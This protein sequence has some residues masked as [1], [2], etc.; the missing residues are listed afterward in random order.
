MITNLIGGIGLFLLGMLLMT[1]GLRS[2]AGDALRRILSRFVAGPFSA[3]ASGAGVT[4]VVQSSSAVTL[5]TIGFVSAGLVTFPQ[6][7]GV[8]LGA[9]LGTT[10]TG[11][12]V[13]VLGFKLDVGAVAL[14]LVGVGAMARLLGSGRWA[15][16]GTALCGF[17][18]IFVGIDTLQR[19]MEGLADHIDVSSL[20][21]VGAGHVVLLVGVGA[22]MTVV[23]QS[24]SAAVATTLTAL[25]AG[26][27]GLGDAAVLV[28][29]QNVGTT[30]TA[31]LAGLGASVPARRTA[32]AHILFNI[33]AAV[34][35]LVLM[36]VLLRTAVFV[37]G[38][39]PSMALAAF[40]TGFNLLGVVLVVPWLR[41]FAAL[42]ERLVPERGPALSRYLDA[43]VAS[44]GP[45]AIEAARRALTEVA[46]VAV[47]AARL[48][49]DG[50]TL[51]AESTLAPARAALAEL[52][53]F[54]AA[55][56]S[57]RDGRSVH[58]R[59]VATLHALDHLERLVKA[60]GEEVNASAVAEVLQAEGRDFAQA[61]EMVEAWT[62]GGSD[63]LVSALA[64]RSAAIAEARRAQRADTLLRT[65]A[66]ELD[67]ESALA[68]NEAMR[69]FDR[70]A[71]H[72]WR[73]LH[74]LGDGA[75]DG[76]EAFDDPRGAD[77][78]G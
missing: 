78:Y 5:A 18:L 42:V 71:Y 45:V 35:A 28:V 62:G 75:A 59:H 69:W 9:N 2:A 70:L 48:R 55:V 77:S 67:P 21:G 60:C 43:S 39:E 7:I 6:A 49:L 53:G 27:I 12:I 22:A 54:L 38:G 50:R 8:L 76:S 25:H 11:W 41:P 4:M 26:A 64:A 40:H 74:H 14:P 63:S 1:E 17:G 16:Y 73:A 10:S 65:A 13:S 61:L 51:E 15:A 31:A 72:L 23:L 47:D 29:G 57:E 34:A 33:V 20:G 56:R 37:A 32:A 52:R 44:V 66:G 36:P 24:S 46:Q 58:E 19:A 3:L 68:R 30:V